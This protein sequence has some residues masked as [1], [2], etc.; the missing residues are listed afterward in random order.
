MTQQNVTE[1]YYYYTHNGSVI[2]VRRV[3]SIQQAY[4][5]A[6]S[7]AAGISRRSRMNTGSPKWNMYGE[8]CG[9]M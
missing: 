1:G 2:T 9:S 4:R 3:C 7:K 8:T 6:V 5:R